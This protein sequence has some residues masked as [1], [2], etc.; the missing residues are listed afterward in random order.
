MLA[1]QPTVQWVSAPVLKV[2]CNG[3]VKLAID[4]RSGEVER[5][6]GFAPRQDINVKLAFSVLTTRQLPY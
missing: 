3:N 4:F 1:F 5:A 6:W 2:K